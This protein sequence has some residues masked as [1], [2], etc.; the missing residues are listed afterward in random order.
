LWIRS[1]AYPLRNISHVGSRVI[2]PRP[3]KARAVKNFIVRTL[4]CLV[5]AGAL[6]AGSTT[7][8]LLVL[9][10]G[11]A[12]LIWR[13]ASTLKLRTIYGLILNTSGVQQDAI[14][15]FEENEIR[16]LVEA[17][18]EAIDHPDTGQMI[19]K[20][21]NVGGDIIQQFGAGNVG[22]QQMMLLERGIVLP[23]ASR[24]QSRSRIRRSGL[25]LGLLDGA[26]RAFDLSAS[27]FTTN[28]TRSVEEILMRADS[29]RERALTLRNNGD[30]THTSQ[31][32]H[33]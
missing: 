5:V 25:L 17:I 10:G 33:E 26:G 20:V 6:S 22:K 13:L 9:L 11:M 4:I 23:I 16:K 29:V 3:I 30:R 19:I 27:M 7:A 21:N 12:L 8:A 31:S 14:W 28:R 1:E 18:I 24:P 32:G 2:D 15:S